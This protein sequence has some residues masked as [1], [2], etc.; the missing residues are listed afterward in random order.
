[1]LHRTV[2]ADPTAFGLYDATYAAG[3]RVSSLLGALARTT[4]LAA[5]GS[6]T[7]GP[8]DEALDA[9]P[10]VLRADTDP[11]TAFVGY[12]STV[13]GGTGGTIT[14]AAVR[15]AAVATADEVSRLHPEALAADGSGWTGDLLCLL[16][17]GFFASVVA[18]FLRAVIAEKVTFV[19]PAL[20]LLDPEDHVARG[21]F[22]RVL[23]LLPN[24][25]EEAH[26][27]DGAERRNGRVAPDN[28]ASG[29]LARVA[30]D[31]LP[32]TVGAALG[33]A[34]G[35]VYEPATGE[36]VPAT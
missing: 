18:E 6:A 3:E 1:M 2:R 4:T 27:A 24:P 15:R 32:R 26:L 31:L 34:S 17:Q 20:P 36:E 7:G 30:R 13:V 5:T 16:Y 12:V 29:S 25:C 33:L 11:R 9:I 14:D 19:L 35:S 28:S 21:V 10:D 23:R 8:R 22:E